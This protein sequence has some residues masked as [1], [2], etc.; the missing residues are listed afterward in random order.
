MS[1]NSLALVHTY[2]NAFEAGAGPP[3]VPVAPPPLA[4]AG[5]VLEHV[6]ADGEIEQQ[7]DGAADAQVQPDPPSPPPPSLIAQS[8][9]SSQASLS[10]SL[11]AHEPMCSPGQVVVY[12]ALACFCIVS[13]MFV[14]WESP[15]RL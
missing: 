4:T 7:Q 10:D 14:Y 1:R 11:S 3:I 9:V 13:L 12:A 6:G 15:H 5:P 2:D 8:R